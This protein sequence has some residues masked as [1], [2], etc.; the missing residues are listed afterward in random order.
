MDRAVAGDGEMPFV[1]ALRSFRGRL[2]FRDAA[3]RKHI[4]RA[5]RG[6]DDQRGAGRHRQGS[7]RGKRAFLVRG[8]QDDRR[9]CCIDRRRDPG[10]DP[11]IGRRQYAVPVERSRGAQ[12]AL[13]AGGDIGREQHHRDQRA[14][15]PG[16]V[17]RQPRRRQAG[18]NPLDGGERPLA[19]RLPQRLGHR[20]LARERI[21]Q[22]GRRAVANAGAAVEPAQ[23]LF[24]TRPAEPD[25]GKQGDQ[26]RQPEQA[27][28]DG[29]RQKRQRQPQP[30]PGHHQKQPDDGQK[31]RQMRPTAFPG[32]R[33][34][35]PL[36]CL[37]ELEPRNGVRGGAWL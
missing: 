23:T 11:D 6:A 22:R 16:I 21:G 29:A 28:P 27:K 31:P 25:E 8:R 35:R 19:L 3:A 26:R 1:G 34:P 14:Q 4:E 2:D 15:R 30:G 10:I 20:I 36:Q 13:I 7:G 5:A 17:D 24:A 12:S 33:I 32:D 37:R 18:A 9:L